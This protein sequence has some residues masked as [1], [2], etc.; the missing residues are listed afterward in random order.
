MQSLVLAASGNPEGRATS[1][2]GSLTSELQT[3]SSSGYSAAPKN[4]EG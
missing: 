3:I 4:Q 1:D 2:M